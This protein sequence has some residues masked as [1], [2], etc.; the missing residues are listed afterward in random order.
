MRLKTIEIIINGTEKVKQNWSK[1]H[2][3]VSDGVKMFYEMDEAAITLGN[4]LAAIP[5]E[6]VK[7][8]HIQGLEGKTRKPSKKEALK[9]FGGIKSRN[10]QGT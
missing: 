8:P 1:A 6:K 9:F 10:E 3:N 4:S 2:I 7:I 5:A